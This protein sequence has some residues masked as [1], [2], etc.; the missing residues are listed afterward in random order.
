MTNLAQIQTILAQAGLGRQN[1]GP[2]GPVFH[3]PHV[4]IM[5]TAKGWTVAA[6][7]T[8]DPAIL[9]RVTTQL[10]ALFAQ[11]PDVTV[12]PPMGMARALAAQA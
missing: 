6:A 3:T 10:N 4:M 11:V 5:R 2:G 7:H 9:N 8:D 1:T 12:G